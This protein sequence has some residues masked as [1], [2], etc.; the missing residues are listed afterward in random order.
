[1]C[2]FMSHIFAL[3]FVRATLRNRNIT[4]HVPYAHLKTIG[5]AAFLK[6][7]K[8]IC[9]TETT[10][11][12]CSMKQPK[13][14]SDVLAEAAFEHGLNGRALAEKLQ[15]AP[16]TAY[17]WLQ[18]KS[19]P[20]ISLWPEIE[21]LL[22]LEEGTLFHVRRASAKAEY[23]DKRQ[24]MLEKVAQRFQ[25]SRYFET[26]PE[27]YAKFASTNADIRGLANLIGESPATVTSW[28]TNREPVP[29]HHWATI[30]E[31]H[32]FDK[33]TFER[34]AAAQPAKRVTINPDQIAAHGNLKDEDRPA[35]ARLLEQ[36]LE[37]Q[38]E[39]KD[40]QAKIL[41]HLDLDEPETEAEGE[42]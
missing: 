26:F 29:A 21:E 31:R 34:I 39:L 41:K 1:M 5:V 3:I 33:G 28:I 25:E 32:H 27:F 6:R 37:N 15:V 18:G 38:A 24:Q 19:E 36:I 23:E 30:E 10:P 40:Q 20:D 8:I 14:L 7:K 17:R 22:G 11:Y 9:I 4:K 13:S 42:P 16:S 2:D 12:D 35:M